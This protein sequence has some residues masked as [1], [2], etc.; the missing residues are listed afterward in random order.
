MSRPPASPG[1]PT[2]VF[3]PGYGSDMTGIK[4]S[5]IDSHCAALGIGCL[6]LDYS[7]TGSSA[8][9]FADGTLVRW[10]DE[11]VAAIDLVPQ[12]KLILV[13][14][15]M[16]G[17]LALHVALRRPERVTALLGIAAAPDFT[18]WGFTPGERA[19]LERDGRIER[20]RPDGSIAL[21]TLGFLQSGKALCLLDAPVPLSIPVRLI[22]GTADAAVPAAIALRLFEQ[23]APG[24]VQLRLIK[25]AGHNL[26]NPDELAAILAELDQLVQRAALA[27]PR[28]PGDPHL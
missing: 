15:S 21:Q 5:A 7:G 2:I 27:L 8:G 23:I 10:L 28:G 18:E 11:V 20:L 17:W 14:S 19:V 22:H 26:S 25:G 4:A 9:D 16:G 6:R 12:G 3:L 24:D 13:G 1:W